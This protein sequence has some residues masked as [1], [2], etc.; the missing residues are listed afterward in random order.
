MESH[1]AELGFIPQTV[2]FMRTMYS[3]CQSISQSV[4]STKTIDTSGRKMRMGIPTRE[5]FWHAVRRNAVTGVLDVCGF[6]VPHKLR[7]TVHDFDRETAVALF[8]F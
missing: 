8:F 5:S 1:P 3:G 2:R 6:S 4:V 7:S